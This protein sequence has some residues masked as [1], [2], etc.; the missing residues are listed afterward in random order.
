M[1][2]LFEIAARYSLILIGEGSRRRMDNANADDPS[3]VADEAGLTAWKLLSEEPHL[4]KLATIYQDTNRVSQ[5]PLFMYVWPYTTFP[6][7]Q[8]ILI[9]VCLSK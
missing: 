9:I 1:L 2:N 7:L 5:W 8:F 4:Q 3:L 6:L